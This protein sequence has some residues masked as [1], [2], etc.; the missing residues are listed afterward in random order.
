MDDC[1]TQISDRQS[2]M[3]LKVLSRPD[4]RTLLYTR[5]NFREHL[6]A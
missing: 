5:H 1:A 3:Y 4:I 2:E 6:S